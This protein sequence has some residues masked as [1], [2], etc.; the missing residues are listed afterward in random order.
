MGTTWPQ[1]MQSKASGFYYT[2]LQPLSGLACRA[3]EAVWARLQ[4]QHAHTACY[5]RS[6]PRG[7]VLTVNASWLVAQSQAPHSLGHDKAGRKGVACRIQLHFCHTLWDL[8]WDKQSAA[9]LDPSDNQFTVPYDLLIG[10]DGVHSKTRRLYQQYDLNMLAP[11][12]P[13]LK[14]WIEFSGIPAE[15]YAKGQPQQCA[16]ASD[17]LLLDAMA[18]GSGHHDT[19]LSQSIKSRIPMWHAVERCMCTCKSTAHHAAS[20]LDSAAWR[21][22]LLPQQNEP[23]PD[24][25]WVALCRCIGVSA[26]PARRQGPA[27]QGLAGQE[28]WLDVLLLS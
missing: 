19:V 11:I 1:G 27:P 15:E 5:V 10:A 9:F 22:D 23:C 6:V 2:S 26:A 25:I 17:S 4:V 3:A 16:Q 7:P 8:Y 18:S 20:D 13:A 28:P 24:L 21:V 14:D 12:Q